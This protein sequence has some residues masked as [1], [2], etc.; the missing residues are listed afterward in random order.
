MRGLLLHPVTAR[1][2][3]P[4]YP[5]PV[6][7]DVHN[8]ARQV[9][10]LST[11]A[12]VVPI[13][14]IV[15][16]LA[17]GRP[18][19]P[20][21]VHLS[22]DDGFAGTLAAAEVLDR[23]RLPW[24]LFVTADAVLDGRAPWFVR[25]ADAVWASS[26][27]LDTN[28]HL[29]DVSDADGK[30]GFLR[31]AMAT[32]LAAPVGQQA[33]IIGRILSLPGM[34]APDGTRWPFLRLDEL[35]E[36]ASAGVTIGSHS[37]THADLTRVRREQLEEEV[38]ARRRLEAVLG[39]PVLYFAYPHGR[40]NRLVRQAVRREHELAVGGRVTGWRETRF[41]LGR[42]DVG[43]DRRGL[44]LA[45]HPDGPSLRTR[46]VRNVVDRVDARRGSRAVR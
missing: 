17:E 6:L 39:V 3:H 15:D 36:L 2:Q 41:S 14:E 11:R 32:V 18:S 4:E 21:T 28:G 27:V 26:N 24:T 44:D 16:H 34:A 25:I 1:R 33:D 8:L 5:D 12:R 43:S 19:P 35:K 20:G 29:H 9:G 23:H 40:H 7:I 46:A 37:A 38:A 42:H 45:L 22:I 30:A 31:M 13:A 10:A